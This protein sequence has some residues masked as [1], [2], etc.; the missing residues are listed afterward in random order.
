MVA[1]HAW[2]RYHAAIMAVGP[3]VVLGIGA[4]M[5]VFTTVV[6]V[7]RRRWRRQGAARLATMLAVRSGPSQRDG[8]PAA[9]DD[10]PP[11]VRRYLDRTIPRGM[12]PV[13]VVRVG[14]AGEFRLGNRWKPFRAT[15]VFRIEPPAFCWD[16]DIRMAPGLHV[17]VRDAYDAGGG[18]TRG[19]LEGLITIVNA[20]GGPEIAAAA[21]QR[22]L[23][24][25]I[26]FPMALRPGPR[27]AWTP[28]DDR[29]ARVTL[30][31]G[32]TRAVIEFRFDEQGELTGIYT[33]ARFREEK[34][35]F[36]P[37][38]WGARV[39]AWA[40]HDDVRVASAV[41]V[42]WYEAAG[43]APFY[44]G[45]VTSLRYGRDGGA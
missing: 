41:E 17:L 10:V 33:P 28:V 22:F 45:R 31:D 2:S 23:A 5:G 1:G 13:N 15:Q 32:A 34:G 38:P 19:A 42:G 40:S 30:T 39:L 43:F 16:A 37:M 11:I 21:L 7:A 18:S 35:R 25:A 12:P 24:E 26:W 27:V 9:S 8:R 29:R 3:V 36:V 20:A 4:L 44:R 14:Q 6:V